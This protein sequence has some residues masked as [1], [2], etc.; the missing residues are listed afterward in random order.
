MAIG[1]TYHYNDPSTTTPAT[2]KKIATISRKD[3]T[4]G[5]FLESLFG[6]KQSVKSGDSAAVKQSTESA[7]QSLDRYSRNLVQTLFSQELCSKFNLRS[8]TFN[9][10]LLG[11]HK[12]I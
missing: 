12:F 9:L 3:P 10:L 7:M 11:L 8:S 6:V 4:L 2:A 5:S 1:P